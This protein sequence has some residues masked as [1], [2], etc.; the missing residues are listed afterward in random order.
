MSKLAKLAK[1]RAQQREAEQQQPQPLEQNDKPILEEDSVKPLTSSPAP[2]SKL[3]ALAKSRSSKSTTNIATG[4]T[5]DATESA[6]NVSANI[7]PTNKLHSSILDQ[8]T[9]KSSSSES[10][11]LRP[12]PALL[13][14]KLKLKNTGEQKTQTDSEVNSQ[15]EHGSISL[16]F[17]I[18]FDIQLDNSLIL[19]TPKE[20]VSVLWCP[21]Q[22]QQ[23]QQQQQLQQLYGS[24]QNSNLDNTSQKRRKLLGSILQPLTN[25]NIST[26]K[27]TKTKENF[28]KPSPDDEVLNAQKQAFEGV[29]ALLI[30]E[31]KEQQQQQIQKDKNSAAKI[32]ETKPFKKINIEDEISKNPFFAKPHKSFVVIGHVDAGKSTLM[33]RLLFDYGIVDAKTVN[34]LVKESE[35][36]G[37]GSFALAW[38]MDQTE[39]ERSHGVTVDICATDFEVAST[40]FTAIDA[41][42]HKDFVPQMIS[43]VSNAD[44]ALLVIDSI[45]GEFEAGFALDGQTKEHTILAK[46]FGVQKLCVVVN[47]M[48]K[49][50]WSQVRFD[51]IKNQMLEYL[52]SDE[53]GFEP[54]QVDFIPI[55]GLTGNNVVKRDDSINAFS[56]YTGLTLGQYL[57]T[58][59]IEDQNNK[60]LVIRDPFYFSV[61][62]V[63][64][65]KGD[66]KV[67]GKVTSG[68]VQAGE[69]LVAY[70]SG[71]ALQVQTVKV[72]LNLVDFA[73]KG[74]LATLSF[75][76]SQLSNEAV[77]PIRVGDIL[78][79]QGTLIKVT[80]SF[81]AS[82]HLFNMDKPLIVG[83]P[84]VLFRNS[85]QTPARISNI[86]EITNSDKKKKK[87]K[88]ILHLNSKQTA[89]V[90]IEV[91]EGNSIPITTYEDNAKI[92]RIVLRREGRTIGAGTVISTDV[93]SKVETTD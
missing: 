7:T 18:P 31:Q 74:Q 35:K 34:K 2:L 51:A 45:T 82:I 71:E 25:F 68:Y 69:T 64:R 12:L 80:K 58:I 29:K 63:Y 33:G 60:Q 27:T 89:I 42:G 61:Q 16:P 77:D 26:E 57:E 9:N 67:N 15:K 78:S 81:T 46:N 87:K 10:L 75:K 21:E 32:K 36:I 91:D 50:D 22:K 11:S 19:E 1:L 23:K 14:H 4:A 52:T 17:Q 88:K 38:I 47:K 44:F 24:E 90:E 93:N 39:E 40:R 37:K 54:S 53:V 72:A 43:G 83:M 8:F 86:V 66:L 49:E 62:D 70:P 28:N 41:P 79:K 92:G 85:S 30:N 48:D 5:T 59:D 65:D 6:T 3:A 73:I 20:S 13:R 56:W 55:S 76:T 84:F